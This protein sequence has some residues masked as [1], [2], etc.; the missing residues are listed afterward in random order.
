MTQLLCNG[1]LLDLY[2]DTSLQF[3][4][5]NSLFTFGE[6]SAERTT[7]FKLP[8]TPKNDRVF[9]L[10]RIPA[11]NGAGMRRTFEAQ[12]QCGTIVKN[13]LLYISEWTGK[14]YTAIMVV[15]LA[16]DI[17]TF[18][19]EQFGRLVL[20]IY[21][22]TLRDAD[23]NNLPIV[24]RV[25]YHT[26]DYPETDVDWSNKTQFASVDI[27]ALFD[28]INAQGIFKITGTTGER[29]RLIRNTHTYY[30]RV[31][32]KLIN[33]LSQRETLTLSTNKQSSIGVGQMPIYIINPNPEDPDIE[34][35]ACFEATEVGGVFVTFPAN[36][37]DNL[38]ICQAEWR[39]GTDWAFVK[40]AGTRK[41][42]KIGNDIVYSGQP[43]KGQTIQIT[44]EFVLMDASGV[45]WTLNDE[46]VFY[47][48][49]MSNVPT[50]ELDVVVDGNVS[51]VFGSDASKSHA[52]LMDLNF[53]ELLKIYAA[54]TG[55]LICIDEDG[56]V[57]FV[58]AV[59]NSKQIEPEPTNTPSVTRTFSNY[60]QRNIIEFKRE[61]DDVF[62]T[63]DEALQVLYTIN[64]VNINEKKTLLTLE[65]TA[66]GV[67]GDGADDLLLVRGFDFADRLK[68]YELSQEV[69]GRA[70]ET[71]WMQRVV[72]VKNAYLQSL[73]D[74][75]TKIK[76]KLRM[77]FEKYATIDGD[78]TFLV[79]N[80][81]YAWTDADW[82]K[83][84][85]TLTLQK[86]P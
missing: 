36:T 29:V 16:Y 44:G 47:G 62:T 26:Y 46:A 73:C 66:G 61:N 76:I 22:N 85:A 45:Y 5:T 84:V 78:T 20:P 86:M 56:S 7:Q 30:E 39:Q 81:L 49:D 65:E 52:A 57:R 60:A 82:T 74:E 31:R 19:N 59:G 42:E 83:D 51:D 64:N 54:C 6:M 28:A 33:T 67:Y 1:V 23:E 18:G 35:T 15:G 72:L 79:D 32:D 70:G 34:Y 55:T 69:V 80:I 25:K 14:E 75:S 3:K 24:A 53:A 9:G 13:G 50:Y 17:K 77:T 58:N 12:L 27:G 71:E 48:G 68:G 38:C 4:K 41:F 11:Y 63:D 10:A 2:E 37:P 8:S 21:D 43:I 40:F